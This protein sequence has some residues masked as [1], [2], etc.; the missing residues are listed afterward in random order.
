MSPRRARDVPQLCDYGGRRGPLLGP[1]LEAGEREVGHERLSRR[2][3]PPRPRVRQA[4]HRRPP[5]RRRPG[6]LEEVFHVGDLKVSEEVD[7]AKLFNFN[8]YSMT[9]WHP[10]SYVEKLLKYTDNKEFKN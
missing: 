5:L 9:E 2:R 10:L 4:L 3:G 1:L 6:V 7:S 8:Q